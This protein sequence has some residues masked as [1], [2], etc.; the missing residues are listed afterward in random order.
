M[1][2]RNDYHRTSFINDA[3]DVTIVPITCNR[4]SIYVATLPLPRDEESF[5]N[6]AIEM[7]PGVIKPVL[8]GVLD[9]FDY[10]GFD[11][12]KARDLFR[13]VTR[14]EKEGKIIFI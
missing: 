8:D 1:H 12:R 14:L 7:T 9:G 11:G 10:T 2:S 4:M 5:V 13:E 6:A 3:T